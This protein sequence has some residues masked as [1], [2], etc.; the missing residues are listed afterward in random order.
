[1]TKH[2]LRFVI[3]KGER[4]SFGAPVLPVVRSYGEHPRL[5]VT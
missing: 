5:R 4:R 3:A 1:M 2:T